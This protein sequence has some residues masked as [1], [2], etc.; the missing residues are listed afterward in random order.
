[1]VG[2]P[3]E[4]TTRVLQI[5]NR[6]AQEILVALENIVVS[7]LLVSLVAPKKS[8]IVMLR[9]GESLYA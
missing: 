7:T 4:Y 5:S 2:A 9:Y 8:V 6:F 3:Q 1:L